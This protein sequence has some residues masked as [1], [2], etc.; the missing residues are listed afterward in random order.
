MGASSNQ[1]LMIYLIQA[2]AMGFVGSLL[3]AALGTIIQLYLPVLVQDFIPV[4]IELFI[5]WSSV[6]IGLITGVAIS[7]LFALIPLLAVRK[8]SPLFTLR[9]VQVNLL[10]LL[11]LSTKTILTIV[12][13]L[14]VTGYAWI[15]LLDLQ[16]AVFSLWA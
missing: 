2:T 14:G 5:S 8:I 3:G 12:V 11:N 6:A 1:A 9:S 4:D 10:G 15:M 7:V 16:A 13:A